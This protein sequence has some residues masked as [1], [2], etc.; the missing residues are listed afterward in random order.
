MVYQP[1]FRVADIVK[2]GRE[3]F[4]EQSIGGI[5]HVKNDLARL[6]EGSGRDLQPLQVKLTYVGPQLKSRASV[7]FTTFYH[8]V[9]MSWFIP[10]RKAGLNYGNDDSDVLNFTVSV[11][12]MSRVVKSLS[13]MQAGDGP[14]VAN[15][16]H[17][18]LMLALKKS[19]L[20]D[21]AYEGIYDASQSKN[22]IQAIRDTLDES[23]GV[24]RRVVDLYREN[25]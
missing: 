23:N 2:L 20:G 6:T 9:D 11:E 17:V 15:L 25:I 10:M 18:S 13:E 7:A 16:P 3:A 12:E 14:H 21:V 4:D 19:R 8:V 1:R 24:G 5:R 22:V